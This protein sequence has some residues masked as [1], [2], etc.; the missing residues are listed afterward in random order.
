MPV[1]RIVEEAI[2]L[3]FFTG[4]KFTAVSLW[5]TEYFL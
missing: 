4:V 5:D 2:F 1:P 3:E